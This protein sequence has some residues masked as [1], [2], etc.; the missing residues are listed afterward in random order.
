MSQCD[1]EWQKYY[2]GLVDTPPEIEVG[3]TLAPV[4]QLTESAIVLG[5]MDNDHVVYMTDSGSVFKLHREELLDSYRVS[6]F[7]D[8]IT[9]KIDTLIEG[10]EIVK[11]I[12]ENKGGFTEW[13]K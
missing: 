10:L 12:L 4:K 8:N 5:F 6:G 2:M 7:C 13:L 11:D 9:D 3:N 1:L